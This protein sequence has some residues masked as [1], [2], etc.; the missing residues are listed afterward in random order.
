MPTDLKDKWKTYRQK[1]RDFPS[2]M[3]AASVTPNGAYY[4]MPLSPDDEVLPTD[5][6]LAI[7]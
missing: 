4:M 7:S 2:T 6:G 3:A 5:G 1:L